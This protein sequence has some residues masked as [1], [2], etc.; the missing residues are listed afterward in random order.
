MLEAYYCFLVYQKHPILTC[1][2]KHE[3][4]GK[5]H[6]PPIQRFIDLVGES[7]S[8]FAQKYDIASPL[9]YVSATG[10]NCTPEL[11]GGAE[12]QTAK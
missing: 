10:V 9:E 12:L 5:I 2:L 6:I 3:G 7:S 8:L 1:L 11:V 4:E